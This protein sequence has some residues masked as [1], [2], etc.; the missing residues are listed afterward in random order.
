[1]MDLKSNNNHGSSVKAS[2]QTIPKNK[3]TTKK[4]TDASKI[5]KPPVKKKKKTSRA[6]IHCQKA[7]LTCDEGRPCQ[8]CIKKNLQ[9]TCRDGI[10]K[11]A[12]YLRD[13]PPE[14]LYNP[15]ARVVTPVNNNNTA[16]TATIHNNSTNTTNEPLIMQQQPQPLPVTTTTH[17]NNSNNNTEEPISANHYNYSSLYVPSSLSNSNSGTNL[18]S[19]TASKRN[20]I[21]NLSF[22][23]PSP[24]DPLN[25]PSTNNNVINNSNQ[26]TQSLQDLNS[27]SSTSKQSQINNFLID[28]SSKAADLE[29][30][31]ISNLLGD[32]SSF[33][34]FNTLNPLSTAA[35][36]SSS[37]PPQTPLFKASLLVDNNA[38]NEEHAAKSFSQD[39][40]SILNNMDSISLDS[41]E[42]SSN[43]TKLNKLELDTPTSTTS[44]DY[45]S[46]SPNTVNTS[47]PPSSSS[48]STSNT[49]KPFSNVSPT[50]G[51][52]HFSEITVCP[53]VPVYNTPEEVYH[54]VCAPF[55]YTE[56][57]HALISYL[58]RRF[59]ND[60]LIL[61]AKCMAAYRPSF[62]ATTK[63]LQEEDLI[64]MEKCFQRT[65]LEFKKFIL[66]SGTP[67]VVWRRT[68]QIAAVGN[69]FCLLTNWSYDA[70]VGT[71]S[72]PQQ[73]QQ[74][75]TTNE[76]LKQEKE[77]SNSMFI[78]QIMDDDSV[79]KYFQVFT[80]L[81]FGDSRGVI[82][83]DCTLLNPKGQKIKTACTWT[84]K[85]DVFDIPMMIIG[86]FL[87]IL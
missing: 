15:K 40:S 21:S 55:P 79:I 25:R 76:Q 14:Q 7:H 70:L 56:G 85:R 41:D 36:T 17:T 66:K 18:N 20:S 71:S 54:N 43:H 87:P 19:L 23:P 75:T 1:M 35:Y 38:K 64:F 68:G 51:E 84:V 80:R 6:C 4:L 10:R 57:Y 42:H 27:L 46:Y 22:L 63:T 8:R 50:L 47:Q 9:D 13:I 11:Q 16:S 30:S 83:T 62:I 31:S 48:S 52:T 45:Y 24:P 39:S 3:K 74:N 72:P 32:D 73:N 81:A 5:S 12:K 53:N 60:K 65:L 33:S 86:N 77:Q 34:S 29:Y 58:R 82:M 61:M 26:S 49:V 37:S 28:F 2:S 69:E 67:T 44:T 59:S 78:M